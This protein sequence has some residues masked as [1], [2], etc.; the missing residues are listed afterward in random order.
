MNVFCAAEMLVKRIV[1]IGVREAALIV[2]I[3]HEGP[4]LRS[5][6]RETSAFGVKQ[7]SANGHLPRIISRV[8]DPRKCKA[9][10]VATRIDT[11]AA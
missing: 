4:A 8:T 3:G 5:T 1:L 11:D 2:E 6:C 9:M 7:R 10:S